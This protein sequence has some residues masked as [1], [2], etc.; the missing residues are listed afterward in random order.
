MR[1]SLLLALALCSGPAAAA[2]PFTLNTLRPY[3]NNEINGLE[4][5]HLYL[6][7][8]FAM[9]STPL[10]IGAGVR[11]APAEFLR[12]DGQLTDA[13]LG[14]ALYVLSWGFGRPSTGFAG[15]A[16]LNLSTVRPTGFPNV[17]AQSGDQV[18][19]IPAIGVS[20]VFF[21]G[22]AYQ[23]F[24]AEF[25]LHYVK[26]AY[27]AD[28][29][30]R[31]VG[32]AC[33][34]DPEI[35]CGGRQ[36]RPGAPVVHPA[37]HYK[38]EEFNYLINLEHEDGY[39]LGV[40]ISN[41]HPVLPDG[42]LGSE[43]TLGGIRALAQPTQLKLDL[44]GRLGFGVNHYSGELDYYGD[45]IAA[46]DDAVARGVALP[47]A[48]GDIVELALLTNDIAETGINARVVI[49]G[50]P[51]PLFRLAE[52]SYA[53]QGGTTGLV[54]QAGARVRALFRDD[55]FTPSA[56]AYAG[57][58]WIFEKDEPDEGDRGL[59]GYLSYSYNAPDALTFIPLADS[60]VIGLQLVFGNPMGLPP[61]VPIIRYPERVD[62]VEGVKP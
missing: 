35:G 9:N 12:T 13:G 29:A 61:P 2:Q 33:P 8:L 42:T 22:L 57:L 49:Q 16:G 21:A 39:S 46:I 20:A 43:L 11:A 26:Q 28:G 24:A 45:Q 5:N 48:D 54:P 3:L 36:V 6:Q 47:P 52:V 32:G 30:G 41:V 59:S 58:F 44:F 10:T 19:F 53:I 37:K 38:F 27:D 31:F 51:S 1:R 25:G 15:F 50:L 56:D 4:L 17:L 34:N 40:V 14:K 60:H 62:A 18:S 7:S 55:G 23:G